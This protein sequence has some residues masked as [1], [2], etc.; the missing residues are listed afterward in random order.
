V[1]L[2]GKPLQVATADSGWLVQQLPQEE[3]DLVDA[4]RLDLMIPVALGGDDRE[5]LLVLGRKLSEEPYDA[6]DVELLTAIA[7]SISLLLERPTAIPEAC[8]AFGECPQCGRCYDGAVSWCVDDGAG[9]VT[10]GLSRTLGNRYTLERR[11]GRG[12]MGTV[13]EATDTALDRQVAVKVIREDLAG[14]PSAAERFRRE[15]RTAAGFAHPNVVTV[16]DFGVADDARAYLVMERLRGRTLRER[17]EVDGRL[18][19]ARALEVLRDVSSAVDAAHRSQLV[20]RDLKPE[21]VFLAREGD[22]EVAKILDFGIAKFLPSA[23]VQPTAMTESGM[24]VGTMQYMAPEQLA[25]GEPTPLWDLWALALVAYEM[26]AGV[27]PAAKVRG[28]SLF[29]AAS[30]E[31]WTPIAEYVPSAPPVVQEFF[32]RAFATDPTKRPQSARA[33]VGQLEA[34][35]S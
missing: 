3:T 7:T 34:A 8:V 16:Y 4:A 28:G 18:S 5:A 15:A 27:H 17:L 23:N 2:L 24:L 14:N 1:R 10:S 26:L 25:G 6:E 30:A 31:L 11:L 20:H 33:F 29:A 9:L 21:N 12:G 19:V 32:A 22:R 13:Y 35:L